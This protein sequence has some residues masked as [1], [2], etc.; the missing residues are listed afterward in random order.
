MGRLRVVLLAVNSAKVNGEVAGQLL[1]HVQVRSQMVAGRGSLVG[2]QQRRTAGDQFVVSGLRLPFLI[3]YIDDV[4]DVDV[5]AVSGR[6]DSHS[7]SG[8]RIRRERPEPQEQ[9]RLAIGGG[10]PPS[11]LLAVVA[12]DVNAGIG[13]HYGILLRKIGRCGNR[14]GVPGQ[15]ERLF[16]DFAVAA[17]VAVLVAHGGFR[18][19]IVLSQ[20]KV[21]YAAHGIGAVHGA[22]AVRKDF[23]AFDR[24]ERDSGHVRESPGFGGRRRDA[25]SVYQHQRRPLAQA[26]QVYGHQPLRKPWGAV[27][28][29]P[30]GGDGG[31]VLRNVTN[32]VLDVLQSPPID[33]LAGKHENGRGAHA[34]A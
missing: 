2:A 21:H 1:R 30:A 17:R 9:C 34:A 22:G 6:K 24:A 4:V 7:G 11:A 14:A 25:G 26:P 10:E 32:D 20:N 29:T 12:I 31:V 27:V 28:E 13:G 33:F 15:P 5:G 18:A 23:N 8:R 19:A 3:A 16:D